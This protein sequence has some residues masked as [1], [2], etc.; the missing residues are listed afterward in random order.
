[1]DKTNNKKVSAIQKAYLKA[2][3]EYQDKQGQNSGQHRVML[4]GY[5]DT[6]HTPYKGVIDVLSQEAH[7][8]QIEEKK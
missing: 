7:E 1:M 8:S 5:T 6:I 3:R 2:L 4:N